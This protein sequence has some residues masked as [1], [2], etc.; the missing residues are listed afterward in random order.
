MVTLECLRKTFDAVEAVKDL[1][2]TV[3]KGQAWALIG[4]NGSGKTTLLRLV[5][6]LAKPDSGRILIGGVDAV[7][8]PRDVRPKLAF[9]PAEFGFPAHHNIREY[10]E[11]F[12]CLVG[13]PRPRR[14]A[15][16]DQVLELTDLKDRQNVGVRGLS[17]GN[18]QR[19]LLAKT[20]LNDPELLLLD[21]PA[22]GLDPRAR[23]EVR[24]ILRELTSMGRTII[25]SSHILADLEDICSHAC[26]LEA[27]RQVLAGPLETLRQ[28]ASK[29]A[30]MLHLVLAPA[31]RDRARALLAAHPQVQSCD[32]EPA[33][34]A[35]AS[36]E[37]NC[38][39]LLRLLLDHD[40]EIVEMRDARPDLEAI[41]IESTRGQV[42]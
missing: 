5:A 30:R 21:E 7:A 17:T 40:I 28:N 22:S 33:G 23:S 42:T 8:K 18:R 19:L 12:A 11:Y 13:V 20:L 35:V 41:F 14:A 32:V 2:L 29:A 1:S 27:G 25:I 24:A 39:A 36:R 9:M 6:T 38:N 26:I 31:D 10:L 34:L 15:T 3:E 4:P 16:I 37:A